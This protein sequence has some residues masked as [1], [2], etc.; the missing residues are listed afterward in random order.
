MELALVVSG[1]IALVGVALTVA[2]LPRSHVSKEV[3]DLT[4]EKLPRLSPSHDRSAIA[5]DERNDAATRTATQQHALT[6][7]S[8]EGY[9]ATT[10]QVVEVSERRPGIGQPGGFPRADPR[11]G[12]ARA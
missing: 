4:V 9:Y 1:T 6:L 11:V 12:S 10:E 2:F 7:I 3:A 5:L 8:E